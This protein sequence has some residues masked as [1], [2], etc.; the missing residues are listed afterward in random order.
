ME[1][2][3]I[4]S[5]TR[6]SPSV[7]VLNTSS[8]TPGAVY[9]V[10]FLEIEDTALVPNP[11]TP[12][13]QANFTAFNPP[14]AKFYSE[15][16][17]PAGGT[18]AGTAAV[19]NGVLKLT[20]AAISQGGSFIV[21]QLDG[22]QPVAGF[23]VT[24]RVLVGGGNGADGFSFNFAPDLTAGI[25]EEGGGT[26]LT[27]AFDTYNN[28]TNAPEAPAVEV[29]FGGISITNRLVSFLRTGSEFVDVT[30]HVDTDGTLDLTYGTNVVFTNLLAYTSRISGQ[31]GFGARTGGA[32][33][34]HWID[35]L[36]INTT[37]ACGPLS[38][39]RSLGDVIV[40]W[41]SGCR[42]ETSVNVAG[43]YTNVLNASS[44]Y[45]NS[46]PDQQRFFRLEGQ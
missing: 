5:V 29:K 18:L 31:F 4:N 22:G 42:L 20:T 8:L 6:V 11:L 34:N 37:L 41:N 15:F 45:T 2:V 40:S 21:N 43:P 26:G 30:I 24:F 28:S 32:T 46:F 13:T 33:D 7:V 19:T 44:P 10:V 36:I 27:I 23:H 9:T 14:P 35:N 3:E 1:N 39:V 25:A 38:V 16:C 12:G 17:S